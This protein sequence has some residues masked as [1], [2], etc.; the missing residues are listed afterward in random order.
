MRLMLQR[1]HGPDEAHGPAARNE[2]A[3][4]WRS[5]FGGDAE[6]MKQ[7]IGQAFLP[8]LVCFFVWACIVCRKVMRIDYHIR[9]FVNLS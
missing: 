6:L 8:V 7:V 3:F 5:L 1:R 4:G 2:E 9:M